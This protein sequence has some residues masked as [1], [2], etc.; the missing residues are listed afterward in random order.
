MEAQPTA[1]SEP[2]PKTWIEKH[3]SHVLMLLTDIALILVIIAL[4]FYWKQVIDCPK[5]SDV[6]GDIATNISRYVG[7]GGL[8]LYG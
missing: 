3:W 2:E 5:C 8:K 4:V 6:C 1:Q 7:N